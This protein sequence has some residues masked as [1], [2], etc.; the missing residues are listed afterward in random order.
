[1]TERDMPG[2]ILDLADRII[3]DEDQRVLDERLRAL[4]AAP[5]LL[6]HPRVLRDDGNAIVGVMWALALEL[7]FVVLCGITWAVW[8]RYL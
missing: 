7:G 6:R 3:D 2:D 8:R 1:M 4:G 5:A